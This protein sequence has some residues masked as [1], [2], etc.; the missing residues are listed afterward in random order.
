MQRGRAAAAAFR[1][2]R[3]GSGLHINGFGHFPKMLEAA[4]GPI[5][6]PRGDQGSASDPLFS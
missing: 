5:Q 3:R 2:D 6:H 4:L 1:D